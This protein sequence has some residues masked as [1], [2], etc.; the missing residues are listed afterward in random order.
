MKILNIRT[1]TGPNVYSHQPVLVMKL[2]LED[3]TGKES[4][5]IPGFIDR[6]LARLPGVHDHH[7]ALGRPG[8][9]VERLREGTYFGHIVEHVALELTDPVG[10]STYRGKT[11]SANKPG[12]YLVAVTYKA[13]RAMRFLLQVAVELV[14][15]LV[16]DR[17]YP[18]DEKLEEAKHLVAKHEIGPST[19]AIVTAAERLGIPWTRADED[20][21][22][23]LGLGRYSQYIQGTIAHRT[24]AI[25]VDIAGNK[26]LTKQLLG[27]GGLP[28]PQGC[29]VRTR[30][31]AI[32]CLSTLKLPIVVKPL[33][34]NQG[35]GVSLNLTT[36]EE[37]GEAF[38]SACQI[39][40]DVIV[41]EMFRGFD[42]RVIVVNGK[43]V[44]AAQRIPAH[45]WGDGIHTIRELIDLTNLD[46]RRAMDMRSR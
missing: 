34:G 36:P 29:V 19:R 6:L 13:E 17:P 41:E 40:P 16:D 2:D 35:R 18:L 37:V 21:L 11:V 20:S 4:F 30:E 10:I 3:L 26:E 23:R 24:R 42:Y 39:S 14:Q 25:G 12:L 22:V 31:D 43:M 8:G 33:D 38:D 27:K 1:I 28:V 7:C 46:P 9:F 32:N 15:S 45:V 5:E 44:A